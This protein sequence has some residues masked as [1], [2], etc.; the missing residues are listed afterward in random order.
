M[1]PSVSPASRAS[2]T[3]A[4]S[5]QGGAAL[6]SL[7]ARFL[8]DFA[9]F[10]G[11]QGFAAII[12]VG[13]SAML[14]GAGLLLLIPILSA[15]MKSG[16]AAHIPLWT[17]LKG[18]A[19]LAPRGRLPQLALLL[20]G[21]AALVLI[22]ALVISTRDL[23]LNTLQ[24][25]FVEAQRMLIVQRLAAA[26]WSVVSRLRH[27]RIAELMGGD[28]QQIGVAANVLAQGGVSVVM[29]VS[30]F[31]LAFAL[32]PLLAALTLGVAALGAL[33]LGT[34]LGRV[35]ILGGDVA[36]ANLN[37]MNGALQFLNGLKL[38]IS[39][40]LQGCFVDEFRDTLSGLSAKRI[41][42]AR[43]QTNRRVALSTFAALMG[44]L[45]V[46]IGFGLMGI[47]PAVLMAVLLVLARIAGPATQLQQGAQTFV[48]CLPA[49]EKIKALDRE[50]RADDLPALCS[51]PLVDDAL[52][53]PIVFRD[54]YFRHSSAGKD[55]SLSAAICGLNLALSPGIWLGVAGASGAG[56]T[57]VADLMA[58]LF[59]PDSG[60]ITIGG[61]P[62]RSGAL[63]VWRKQ[64][65]YVSQDPF[66]FHDTIRRNLLWSAADK[67]GAI[68]VRLWE[69]L[70][71]A[72]ADVIV[73]RMDQGM[74]TVVGER[75]VLL[76]GGE[77]QR[78]A[79]ARAVLR[80]PRLL[81]LDEA[82]N[83]ID[84]AGERTLF[85]RLRA[86]PTRPSILIIAHRTESLELCD[87]VLVLENG[88]LCARAPRREM[89]A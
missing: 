63:R 59:T 81:I 82:T 23:T 89:H 80:Q 54:V 79:I 31:G 65:S 22:R 70:H 42:I 13:L 56:K 48:Q 72:G 37:L 24:I 34:S 21:F 55:R 46:L 74:E 50:L 60:E 77:R 88:S 5:P 52:K 66:L 15:A 12:W 76:S 58:G 33:S 87:Q 45:V 38:A 39:Q 29:L 62:L 7:T 57:T 40:D 43:R 44:A 1:F 49:Y 51:P 41:E 14:E 35:F 10:S 83:A 67:D 28:I 26:P 20:S 18:A 64:V 36:G 84:L 53:G 61:V 86:L 32:S 47:Q 25:G 4:G 8:I 3:A 69:A 19:E 6:T 27:A 2:M 71:I 16:D 30:L 9:R 85:E 78:L 11:R 68:D 73:R 75:G 17:V